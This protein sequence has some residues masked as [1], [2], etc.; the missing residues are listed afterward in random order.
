M[1]G[2]K[3]NMRRSYI[4]EPL[5]NLEFF[6][7]CRQ[8]VAF[9]NL[10]L[11]LA[12]FHAL[13]QERRKFGPLGWNIPYGFDD[14]DQRISMRQLRMF[15]DENEEVRCKFSFPALLGAAARCCQLLLR[16]LDTAQTVSPQDIIQCPVVML[17]MYHT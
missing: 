16:V 7:G 11:G 4:Q 1:Q 12:F 3:G 15:L 10:L 13:V 6:E 14:G 2:I 8:P 17:C 5:S 9:K